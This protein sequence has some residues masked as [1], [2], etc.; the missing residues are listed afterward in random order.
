M[1]IVFPAI[2]TIFERWNVGGVIFSDQKKN[3]LVSCVEIV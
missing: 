3:D 2:V 1:Y